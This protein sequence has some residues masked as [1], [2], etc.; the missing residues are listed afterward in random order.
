MKVVKFIYVLF[1]LMFVHSLVSA[2][3]VNRIAYV[4]SDEILEFLP[5]TKRAKAEIEDYNEKY[6]K[7]L[8]L[9]QNEYNKKYSEFISQQSKMYENIKLKRMQ[10]LYELEKEIN[11]FVEV[12]QKDVLIRENQLV[13]NLRNKIKIVI[14]QVG[15][16]GGFE[17]IYDSSNPS[18][19]FIT[20][21]AVDIT[22]AVKRKLY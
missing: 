9:M 4:N 12:S 11:K 14:D 3:N 15:M 20:P 21:T 18:I 19:L 7:E 16:E 13:S 8:L 5:E 2:Q 6:K 1:V 10:E 22:E 17:C